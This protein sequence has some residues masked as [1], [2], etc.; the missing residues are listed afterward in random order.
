MNEC[1]ILGMSEERGEQLLKRSER[2][3]DNIGSFRNLLLSLELSMKTG[4]T[5]NNIQGEPDDTY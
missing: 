2:G 5:Q 4:I 1:R 3:G